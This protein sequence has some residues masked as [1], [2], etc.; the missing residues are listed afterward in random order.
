MGALS[1]SHPD[2]KKE[3][4]KA[5][6]LAKKVASDLSEFRR[7]RIYFSREVA[8]EIERLM[9]LILFISSEFKNVTYSEPYD[10]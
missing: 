8:D 4:V 6:D 10:F 2:G 9:N 3:D 7:K 1:E 5:S